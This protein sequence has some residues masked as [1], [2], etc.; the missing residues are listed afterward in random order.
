MESLEQR[1]RQYERG[2][3]PAEDLADLV[4]DIGESPL[5]N[6]QPVRGELLR[7][8]SNPDALVRQ[9]ALGALAYHGM[10]VDWQTEFGKQ[11]LSGMD[12]MLR[13]D[14][15]RD[16]RRQAAAAFG[17][18]FK[19]T[20]SQ[21]VI[22]ALGRVCSNPDEESDVRAFAYTSLLNVAG[23]PLREQPNPVG[24]MLGPREMAELSRVLASY[25]EG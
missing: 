14:E 6:R 8:L 4:H 7:L 20:K 5:L 17:S 18:L 24:L 12:L 10:A 11:L 16:C 1:W 23:I 9:N 22:G 15:D 2:R 13:L 25:S 19:S 21:S 3:F